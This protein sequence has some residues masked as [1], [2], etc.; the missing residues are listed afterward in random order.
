MQWLI[1]FAGF[2]GVMAV[3]AGV[4]T[5][6]VEA[7]HKATGWRR[8]GL[9]E[10]LRSLHDNVIVAITPQSDNATDGARFARAM[11]HSPSFGGAGRWWWLRRFFGWIFQPRF[12]R[13]STLQF[14]E[15]LGQTE[16]GRSL[17]QLDRTALTQ[18]IRTAAFQFERYG[19]AQSDYFRRRAKVVAAL[20]GLVFVLVANVDALRIYRSLATDS[21]RVDSV[22]AA[23]ETGNLS[24][25]EARARAASASIAELERGIESGG[26]QATG[27]AGAGASNESFQQAVDRARTRI[28]GLQES[29][30]GVGAWA[31]RLERAN[32]PIGQ[33]YFPY[34]AQPPLDGAPGQP[35][36]QARDPLCRDLTPIAIGD[37]RV[38]IGG[39]LRR[40]T[41]PEG[42]L[43]LLSVI[44][45]AGLLGLGAPFWF[46]LF[47]NLKQIAAPMRAAATAQRPT[48][49][50][51]EAQAARHGHLRDGGTVDPHALTEAFLISAGRITPLPGHGRN[52]GP[53]HDGDGGGPGGPIVGMRQLR[54]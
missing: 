51:E 18:R 25:L 13:L 31:Q 22:L 20:V 9:E 45:T 54:S 7:V 24:D 15:Q 38:E 30:D 11:T 48:V 16:A 42:A 52:R 41:T 2:A 14:A 40:L 50:Q 10:M 44:A 12:E 43:W 28:D 29:I 27:L 26:A 6:V 17:L 8:A 1:A 4:V 35:P 19:Q 37:G 46:D 39:F 32:M 47:R 53:R 3:L 36:P 49:D 21:G 34:C 23:V 5:V 33:T